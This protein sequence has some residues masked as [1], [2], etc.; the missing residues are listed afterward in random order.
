MAPPEPDDYLHLQP[1]NL[2]FFAYEGAEWKFRQ[3]LGNVN[4]LSVHHRQDQPSAF[5]QG[6][7]QTGRYE[8]DYLSWRYEPNSGRLILTDFE[9]WGP[10]YLAGD[11]LVLTRGFERL[12]HD[13]THWIYAYKD[14]KRGQLLAT[15]RENDSRRFEIDCIDAASGR[16]QAWSFKPEDDKG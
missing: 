11:Y 1:G 5:L 14:G 12:A 13:D 4:N 6:S 10:F 8:G 2:C 7:R 9:D 16:M 3:F 15:L